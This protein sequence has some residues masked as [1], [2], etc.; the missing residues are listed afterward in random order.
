MEP[1]VPGRGKKLKCKKVAVVI[2]NYNGKSFLE[3]FLP[4]YQFTNYPDYEIVYV[5]NAS[6]D[7]SLEFIKQYYPEI[8]TIYISVNKGFTNG[9]VESL[10]LI[11][12]EYYVL[13]NSDVEVTPGWIKPII[14]LMDNDPSIGACQPKILSQKNKEYF[15]YSGAA[16][17]FIDLFGY[18]FCRGRIFNILEKDTGQYNN[19][20]EVFWATGA[21][22]F[23]RSE[24]YH[25]IGGLDN[26]FYAHMEE[27]DLCW[28]IKNAGYKVMV[29]PESVV[30]HVGGSI[31]SYGS[32]MKLYRNFRNNLAL[33][34]KNLPAEELYWKFSIRIMLDLV[35]FLR[36][37]VTGH[38]REVKAIFNAHLDFFLSLRMWIHKRNA[39]KRLIHNPNKQGIYGKSIVWKFFI[40]K[41]KFFKDLET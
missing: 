32:Y 24:L 28:R 31:I 35:A 10:P 20:M 1:I 6:T 18:P 27:I 41:I 15:E 30:Y 4:G 36:G 11:E 23:V 3:S 8:K 19:T 5:D 2:L 26:D 21:C 14:D 16:G 37:I 34:I 29:C 38:F 7:G 12:S 33:L 39:N 13:I 9:Y 40:R 17:G 22:M 25:R